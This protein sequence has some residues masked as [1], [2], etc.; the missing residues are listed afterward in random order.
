MCHSKRIC[1]DFLVV[2]WIRLHAS[3]AGGLGLISGQE[4]RSH[5]LQFDNTACCS[6]DQR[7]CEPRLRPDAEKQASIIF[8]KDVL[9]S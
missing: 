9:E 1:W 8:L 3:T 2:Q 5:G 7:S 4:T 6:K